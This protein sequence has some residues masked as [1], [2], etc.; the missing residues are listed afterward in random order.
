M[1]NFKHPW[2]FLEVQYFEY[3]SD[4]LS[5]RDSCLEDFQSA[6]YDDLDCIHVNSPSGRFIY[7]S[8]H[9]LMFMELYCFVPDFNDYFLEVH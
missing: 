6:W 7:N 3:F 2:N 8:D 1:D 9:E 5:L 4:E